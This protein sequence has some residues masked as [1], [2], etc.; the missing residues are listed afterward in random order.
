MDALTFIIGFACGVI[1]TGYLW[2]RLFAA[3]VAE[4]VGIAEV[5]KRATGV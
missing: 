4:I 5:L 2:W 1:I 3:Y